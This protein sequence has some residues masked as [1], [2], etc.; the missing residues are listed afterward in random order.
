MSTTWSLLNEQSLKSTLRIP[1]THEKNRSGDN[2]IYDLT[3]RELDIVVLYD[4]SSSPKKERKCLLCRSS[5]ICTLRANDLYT[6][7]VLA[8]IV[9]QIFHW[10]RASLLFLCQSQVL[11]Q[12]FIICLNLQ[13][14][15][16]IY[17]HIKQTYLFTLL[18]RYIEIFT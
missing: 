12:N 11:I 18:C 10:F 15:V 2:L 1:S 16:I 17:S 8:L 3:T 9:T 13:S 5:N 14:H 4:Y 6:H 7:F